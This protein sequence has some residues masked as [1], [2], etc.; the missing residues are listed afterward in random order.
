MRHVPRA[1]A[2]GQKLKEEIIHIEEHASEHMDI[3]L[4]GSDLTE[5]KTILPY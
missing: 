2:I 3:K 4:T 5:K 1:Q